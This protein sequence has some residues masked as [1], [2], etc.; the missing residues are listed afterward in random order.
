MRGNHSID[1][2]NSSDHVALSDSAV[3]RAPRA[4]VRPAHDL[5]YSRCRLPMTGLLTA[6]M[7]SLGRGINVRHDGACLPM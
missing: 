5:E 4:T 1:A 6:T 2:T 7:L 3:H